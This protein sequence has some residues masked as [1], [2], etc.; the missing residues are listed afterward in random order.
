M[1]ARSAAN[2]P[3][4]MSR[5]SNQ[6]GPTSVAVV[7]GGLAGMAAAARAVEHGF[8]VELFEANHHLGGRAGSF[9]D[10]KTGRLVD[11]C[12]HVAMRC[13]TQL[14]DFCRRTGVADCFGRH[15]TLHF[16]GPEATRHDLTAVRLLPAPLHLLPGLMRL[17]YLSVGERLGI[18]RALWKLVR[19]KQDA[20]T[21]GDWLRRH[22][23]SDR[24]IRR[25]WSV[26]L[27]SALG[28]TVDRASLSAARQVFAEGFFASR[29]AYQLEVPTRPLREIFDRRVGRWLAEN[30][31]QVHRHTPIAQIEGD[32]HRATS[33]R[34]SDGSRREFDHFIAAVP[35]HRIRSLLSDPIL[36]AMPA[37]EGVGQLEPAPITAVHFWFDRPIVP[38]PHAV[39]VDRLSQWLFRDAND[40]HHYQVVISASR[41]LTGRPR[42]EIVAEVR[43]DMESIWPEVHQAELLHWRV[44][45]QPSAVFSMRPGVERFRPSQQTPVGNLLLAGDWTATGWP[46]TMEGAVRSGNL[47]IERLMEAL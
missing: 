32:S 45:T 46:A 18:G 26:V 9:V 43:R 35:W 47:A 36:A 16:F 25:F 5:P 34:F 29:D 1:D 39:L 13:C 31:V 23:Q 2:G 7:G 41:E 33:L 22:G 40:E 27:V 3:D 12:Q 15:A 20:E 10:P 24:A 4:A 19:E 37:L 6:H 28:E 42:R 8:R 38:L 44:A 21:I 17:G 14:A 11:H 30:G